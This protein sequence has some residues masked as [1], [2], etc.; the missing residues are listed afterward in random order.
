MNKTAAEKKKSRLAPEIATTGNQVFGPLETMYVRRPWKQ[1]Q[2]SSFARDGM[3]ADKG[4]NQK[5][6]KKTVCAL[7]SLPCLTSLV[8]HLAGLV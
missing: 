3:I 1:P 5:K 7:T 8:A 6:I 2:G 4:K